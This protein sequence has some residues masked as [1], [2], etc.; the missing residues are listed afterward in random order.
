MRRIHVVG[1][2]GAGKTTVAR[3]LAHRLGLAHVELD[4]LYWLPGWTEPPREAFGELL[5]ATLDRNGEG[6]VVD[7]NYGAVGRAI[8]WEQ[9]DTLVWLD[10]P[11][12]TVMRQLTSR[13]LRRWWRRELLW[14]TNRERLRKTLLSRDS[15]LWWAWSTHAERRASYE[16]LLARVPFRV[17]RLASRAE[18][19]AWLGSVGAAGAGLLR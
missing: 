13:T 2:S 3:A 15:I 6:W 11:R 1:T 16:S 8:L 4:A 18:V 17:I 9:I 19:D 7:G 5:K 14:G 12:S 10:L